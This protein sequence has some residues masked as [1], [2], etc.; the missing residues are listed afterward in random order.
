MK[1]SNV[2]IVVGALSVSI[3]LCC[4]NAVSPTDNSL[5]PFFIRPASQAADSTGYCYQRILPYSSSI[6]C[7]ETLHYSYTAGA[8]VSF[9]NDTEDAVVITPFPSLVYQRINIDSTDCNQS[10]CKYWVNG[11]RVDTVTYWSGQY[12][13]SYKGLPAAFVKPIK[14]SL[15]DI[16]YP[17]DT[18]KINY[19]DSITTVAGTTRNN[20]LSIRRGGVMQNLE[21]AAV[22]VSA[23]ITVTQ[24]TVS[25][26]TI[27]ISSSVSP[28]EYTFEFNVKIDGKEYGNIPC[29]IM[30]TQ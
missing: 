9:Q 12:V 16:G 5:E 30:V 2:W 1:Q 20:L 27:G 18:V 26:F 10:G 4:H 23:G 19:R 21:V 24:V 14:T 29:T 13:C 7:A 6:F 25:Y 28:G 17:N 3:L 22:S 8:V 11:I 15:V